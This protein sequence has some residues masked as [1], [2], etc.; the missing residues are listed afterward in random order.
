MDILGTVVWWDKFSGGAETWFLFSAL[1]LTFWVKVSW[2]IESLGLAVMGTGD[3][4][5]ECLKISAEKPYVRHII[6]GKGD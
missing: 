6:L 5:V 2:G 1:S 3:F 4:F